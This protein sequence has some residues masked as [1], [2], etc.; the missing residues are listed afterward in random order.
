MNSSVFVGFRVHSAKRQSLNPPTHIDERSKEGREAMKEHQEKLSVA[1]GQLPVAP[2]AHDDFCSRFV[3]NVNATLPPDQQI[4]TES[5]VS[6]PH[7]SRDSSREAMFD[8]AHGSARGNGLPFASSSKGD[9]AMCAQTSPG[10]SDAALP[11]TS[12]G[13]V[14]CGGLALTA[15]IVASC[16]ATISLPGSLTFIDCGGYQTR[17]RYAETNGPT[18]HFFIQRKAS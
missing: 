8:T 13:S 16:G 5:L 15:E 1:S 10:P 9:D 12:T 11:V 18:G 7:G 2:G 4:T 3:S 17:I 14:P 6:L